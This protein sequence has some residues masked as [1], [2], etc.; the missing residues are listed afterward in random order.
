MNATAERPWY[1]SW[2]KEEES[3]FYSCQNIDCGMVAQ[4][5]KYTNILKILFS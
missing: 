5:C 4:L 1:I 3:V 2:N